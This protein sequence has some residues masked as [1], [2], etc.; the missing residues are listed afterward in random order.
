[1]MNNAATF[2]ESCLSIMG[3]L[4]E[5]FQFKYHDARARPR[6]V[7]VEFRRNE[8]AVLLACEGNVLHADLILK[9]RESSWL[10]ISINQALWFQNKRALVNSDGCLEQVN[11]LCA[12]LKSLDTNFLGG[13]LSELDPRFCFPMSDAEYKIYR[14][15][16]K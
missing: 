6:G 10:R 2:K 16:E 7:E 9:R 15:A 8:D 13:N 3:N 14:G 4:L 1:M 11:T 5:G 12:E